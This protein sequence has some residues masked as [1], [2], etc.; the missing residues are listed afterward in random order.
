MKRKYIFIIVFAAIILFIIFRLASNKSKLNEKERPK[1]DSVAQIP[2]K[3]AQVTRER[4]EINMVKT[5]TLAPFKEAKLLSTVS[6]N[7]LKL[8]FELGDQVKQGQV[9]AIMDTKLIE[10]D[11]Q[12]ART[13]AAKLSRD[14]QTYQELLQGGAAT[15][16]K[17]NELKQDYLDAAN[18]VSQLKKQVA[19]GTIKAPTSGTISL[20]SVEEGVFLTAGTEMATIVN[21]SQAKIQLNLT[22]SEV[23]Q[24]SS[25]QQV[26][27]TTDVYP[28]KEFG[29]KISYISPQADE[30]YNYKLEIMATN[31]SGSPLRS[32]T[33]VYC[34]FSRKTTEN[35]LLIPREAL[36]E[37]VKDATVYVVQN[38]KVKLRPIKTGIEVK[39][40]IQVLN[41]LGAGEVVVT[42]GQINLKDG[43][44]IS[45]SK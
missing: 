23:Y 32:G 29:G 6:G 18:L 45:I 4:R 9:L 40:M 7:V 41:G 2:V 15:Q 1:T 33:F 27:I 39:N 10:L 5:G 26:K 8:R 28:G 42:S 30:T 31:T 37:S 34:D 44:Q 25:G 14:V 38:S 20:K 17:V 11:L 12:K 19:D 13:N 3:T 24:V 35:I 16:E 22:E 21:L 43:S 36:T